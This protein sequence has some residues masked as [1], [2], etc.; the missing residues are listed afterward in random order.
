MKKILVCG[1]AGFIG[2]HLVNYLKEKGHY[3]VGA[4]INKPKF[5]DN[6]DEFYNYDLRLQDKVN[7]LFLDKHFD[8][9]YQLAANMGG[10]GFVFTGDND[11]D[12]MSSS[13]QIHL[14]ILSHYKHFDKIFFSSSAC[15]YNE[16]TQ[17]DLGHPDCR[18]EKAYP[19]GPDSEYGWEKLYAE[20]LYQAYARNYG[21]NIRIARF[22][23]IN[24]V[25]CSWNNGKEKVPAAICRKVAMTKEGGEIELWGDGLNERSFLYI[26]ECL[27]GINRLMASD[28]SGP[29]NIGSEEMISINDL[30]KMV[31]NFSGKELNINNIIDE[32]LPLGVRSRNS[33]NALIKEKLGWVPD[34]PLKDGIKKIYDWVKEQVD[35][36]NK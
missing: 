11:A 14:N 9:V 26:D 6:C 24:G 36:T 23:N 22:H 4:D 12:I 8:E 31:I 5:E 35:N 25:E 19:A 18:E 21:V 10:A 27:N 1:A 7:D 15:V 17:M 16:S 28:F 33:D 34:Y 3:V 13:T 32:G 2:H 20:R 30:A 29:V